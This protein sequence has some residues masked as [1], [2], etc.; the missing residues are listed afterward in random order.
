MDFFSN[1]KKEERQALLPSLQKEK[2]VH[3][4]QY[5]SISGFQLHSQGQIHFSPLPLK[6]K[7]QLGV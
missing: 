7:I 4:Y 2:I 6:C 1:L 3:L 5:R